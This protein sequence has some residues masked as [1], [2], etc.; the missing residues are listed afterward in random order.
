MLQSANHPAS[1]PVQ[2]N[3]LVKVVI[4]LDLKAYFNPKRNLRFF[5][6]PSR[7]FLLH[8]QLNVLFS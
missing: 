7:K 3:P 6:W 5:P 1:D 4:D 2:F 8:L